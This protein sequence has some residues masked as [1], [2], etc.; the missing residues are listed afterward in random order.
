M[1]D[2]GD[3]TMTFD[4]RY[5]ADC[6]GFRDHCRRQDIAALELRENQVSIVKTEKNLR[7]LFLA[8]GYQPVQITI[9]NENDGHVQV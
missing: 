2:V 6:R 9:E 4:F 8:V 5:E 7:A 3:I 1:A